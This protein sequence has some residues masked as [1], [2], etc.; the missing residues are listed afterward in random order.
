MKFKSLQSVDGL[1]KDVR[2]T[3]TMDFPFLG[4]RKDRIEELEREVDQLKDRIEELEEEKDSL[5]ERF[6]SEK[7]RRSKVS[8]EKQEAERKLKKLRQ[9][10][11]VQDKQDKQNE[12]D[13]R[14]LH[15]FRHLELEEARDILSKLDSVSSESDDM[16][17]VYSQGKLS[18]IED[19]RGL[20]NTLEA[21][22]ISAVDLDSPVVAFIDG[23]LF[24]TVIKLRPFF[25]S[26]WYLGEEFN[27]SDIWNFMEEE[28][29]WVI[30]SAG[31]SRIIREKD[32]DILETEEVKT[33]VDHKHTQGGYSQKRFERKRDEQIEEHIQAVQAEIDVDDYFVLGERNLCKKLDG[34]YLGGFDGKRSLSD[35][36]YGFQ[37]MEDHG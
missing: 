13:E 4:G 36:L 7:E 26:R 34:T 20:K 10:L 21:E 28:K 24:S 17:T 33:R 14:A 31:K 32:G 11:E 3:K 6:E 23:S 15:E 35:D 1:K 2:E 12:E 16:V 18:D 25:R 19:Y 9:K 37:I 22:Y 27:L 29:I 30:L 5:Q 8:A